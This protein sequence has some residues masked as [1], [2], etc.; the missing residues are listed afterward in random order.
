MRIRLDTVRFLGNG[1]IDC[2]KCFRRST[3]PDGASLLVFDYGTVQVVR[4]ATSKAVL[5]QCGQEYVWA[6]DE[7]GVEPLNLIVFEK[8]L[9][10]RKKHVLRCRCGGSYVQRK[11]EIVVHGPEEIEYAVTPF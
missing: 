4:S 9:Q 10:S 8:Y 11:L 1:F 6:C 3:F 7:C 5:H 2:R